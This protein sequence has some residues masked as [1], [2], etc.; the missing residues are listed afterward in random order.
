LQPAVL[1]GSGCRGKAK[2]ACMDSFS[3]NRKQDFVIGVDGFY[4][5]ILISG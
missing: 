4:I 2:A 3:F 1:G 5:A